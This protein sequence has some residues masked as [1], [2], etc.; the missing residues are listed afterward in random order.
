MPVDSMTVTD[1]KK[2]P[3]LHHKILDQNVGILVDFIFLVDC[4]S[5]SIA[6]GILRDNVDCL[7]LL[8]F[9]VLGQQLAPLERGHLDILLGLCFG[10]L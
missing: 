7:A 9:A 3:L 6:E 8:D 2:I 1:P 4:H 10:V 5:S